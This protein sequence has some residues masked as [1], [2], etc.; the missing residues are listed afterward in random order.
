M[1]AAGATIRHNMVRDLRSSFCRGRHEIPEDP[2]VFKD[3]VRYLRERRPADLVLI[4][5]PGFNLGMLAEQ[6]HRLGIKVVYYVCPQ[7]W[8]WH[9]S[10]I[11][12]IRKFVDKALVIL[13]FEESYLKQGGVD[14]EFV[15]TPWLDLMMITMNREQVFEHFGL[16]PAKRL[17]GLL[18][19]SR[20]REVEALLPTMLEAAEKIHAKCPDVQFVIPRATTV[21]REIVEHLMTLAQVPVKV[22]ESYRYN[23][24]AAMDLAI[25][26]SGTATLE[27]GLLG[28]PMIIV[29]KVASCRG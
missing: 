5:Y 18:P 27:T 1:E 10:R 23:V 21:R 11:H 29:Y 24:R 13:P 6:A 28:T 7:V 12:K 20:R 2:A 19:G 8:A 17:V 26:A 3:T 25:V 16:D 22:V 9:K 14:A 15:G 4:D